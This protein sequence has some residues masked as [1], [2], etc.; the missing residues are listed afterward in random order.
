MLSLLLVNLRR[1]S[2]FHAVYTLFLD[3]YINV[4]TGFSFKTF[5]TGA[6]PPAG[7]VPLSSIRSWRLNCLVSK[8]HTSEY[9]S[10]N[11]ICGRQGTR[12]VKTSPTSM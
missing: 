3:V 10:T 8:G 4:E 1:Y 2:K 12:D 11:F 9:R 5:S 6:K 7:L